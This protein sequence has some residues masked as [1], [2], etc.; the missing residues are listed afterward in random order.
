MIQTKKVYTTTNML[1]NKLSS[2]SWKCL[3]P[4]S[5]KGKYLQICL[6]TRHI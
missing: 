4:L 6:E 3:E 2:H 1:K 5:N